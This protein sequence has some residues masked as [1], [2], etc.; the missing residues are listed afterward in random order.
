MN[1]KTKKQKPLKPSGKT[2]LLVTWHN[3]PTSPVG[4]KC[5]ELYTTIPS[6]VLCHPEYNRHTLAHYIT[7][8][9][10]SF[11]NEHLT[12]ER[13]HVMKAIRKR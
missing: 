2:L 5:K 12:I 11:V 3:G 1:A 6:F 8:L 7:R 13:V 9:K 10:T 4:E